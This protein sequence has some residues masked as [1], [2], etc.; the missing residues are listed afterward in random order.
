MV[1][2]IL[3]V[4]L[5]IDGARSLKD[6]RRVVA[7]LK[8]RLHQQ[9][10]VSVAEIEQQDNP[11]VARLGVAAVSSQVGHCQGVL[12]RVVK[13]I[14]TTRGCVLADHATEILTGY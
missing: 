3:Q 6:K 9:H 11:R 2:G 5:K 8:D 13:K 12:E 4:E 14:R 7:S 1:V 10:Q